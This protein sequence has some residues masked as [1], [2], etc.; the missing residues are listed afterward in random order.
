MTIEA[1]KGWLS[2]LV[3]GCVLTAAGQA[4]AVQQR[5]TAQ[6]VPSLDN[7]GNN[8]FT[9]TTANGPV[10]R[11]NPAACDYKV[12][13]SY[14]A[15]AS[16]RSP[17]I[18]NDP[19]P[20]QSLFIKLPADWRDITVR[21]ATTGETSQVQMRFTGIGGQFRLFPGATYATGIPDVS[22]AHNA[23][24]NGG[25][26]NVPPAP[27]TSSHYEVN[28]DL[29]VWM[30]WQMSSATP[31]AKNTAFPID[32]LNMSGIELLYEIRTPTPLT[33]SAGSWEGNYSYFLGAGS[34]FDFG[35]KIDF[36]YSSLDL[37]ISLNV[38]HHLQAVFPPGADRLALEPEGG[39][40]PWLARGRR[41]E[42]IVRDQPFQFTTSGPVKMRVECQHTMGAHCAIEN[43]DGHRVPVETRISLPTGMHALTGGP[44]SRVLL[45]NDDDVTAT[46]DRYV[47]N[48]TGTLHFEV[49]R[50][51]VE[52]MLPRAD[53][54]YSGNVT[55]VW[56]SFLMP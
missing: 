54:T 12:S 53:T 30:F 55:V 1:V 20:R 32:H 5:I 39:W 9:N 51:D 6:F 33:M 4:M 40:I 7:P 52:T 44:A 41:P 13:F 29:E 28:S 24:W 48:Q 31:C 23:W 56:D 14:P 18:A 25:G 19:D 36:F 22:A 49:I 34:D 50:R 27:C 35:D 38:S 15:V 8:T 3:V 16:A 2:A 26:L 46:N 47:A 43:P 45:T 21:H 17:I 11:T 42:R 37:M 10:C